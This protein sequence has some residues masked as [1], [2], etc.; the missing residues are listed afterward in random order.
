MASAMTGIGLPT[1]L[2]SNPPSPTIAANTTAP[3]IPP[4]TA[5]TSAAVG[6]LGFSFG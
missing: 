4:A 1:R 5:P 3:A 2:D 6:L